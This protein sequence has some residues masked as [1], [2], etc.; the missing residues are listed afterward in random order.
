MNDEELERESKIF[1]KQMEVLDKIEKQLIEL[2]TEE[3]PTNHELFQLR[4]NKARIVFGLAEK[5]TSKEV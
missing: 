5:L 3:S 2:N 1:N 4:M